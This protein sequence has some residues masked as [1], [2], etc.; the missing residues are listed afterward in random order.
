MGNQ[1]VEQIILNEFLDDRECSVKS[2]RV[3]LPGRFNIAAPQ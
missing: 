3:V 2:E 1:V